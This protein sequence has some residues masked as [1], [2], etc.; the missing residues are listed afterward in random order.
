VSPTVAAGVTTIFSLLLCIS[1]AGAG[2]A[3]PACLTLHSGAGVVRFPSGVG[4][5]LNLSFY[6]SIYGSRVDEQLLVGP[7]GFRITRLR[8]SELRLAEFYGHEFARFE[9]GWWVVEP[10]SAEVPV[11]NFTVSQ[12]SS[13][14]ITFRN[15]TVSLHHDAAHGGAFRLIPSAC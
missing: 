2:D 11:L 8:Y 5:R 9:E 7:N 13:I 14:R 6:H 1:L 10:L 12:D 4:N 15:Q 3:Y